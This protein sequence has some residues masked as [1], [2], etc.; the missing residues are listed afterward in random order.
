MDNQRLTYGQISKMVTKKRAVP[1]QAP[2]GLHKARLELRGLSISVCSDRQLL[3]HSVE[4]RLQAKGPEPSGDIGRR[5][6]TYLLDPPART[7]CGRNE[8][9]S[10]KPAPGP[11]GREEQDP[12]FLLSHHL[13]KEFY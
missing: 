3:D 8:Q 11:R 10:H 7:T 2:S 5:G 1:K 12:L 4:G 9:Q 6:S 13:K